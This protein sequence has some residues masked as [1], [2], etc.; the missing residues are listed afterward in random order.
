MTILRQFELESLAL[1]LGVG[2]SV[3]QVH[4]LETFRQW[5]SACTVRLLQGLRF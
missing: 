4:H 5:L 1:A 3:H 2:S